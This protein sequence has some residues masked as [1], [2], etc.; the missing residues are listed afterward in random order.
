M[1]KEVVLY[2]NDLRSSECGTR[3]NEIQ[4]QQQHLE[5]NK[6]NSSM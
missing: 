3:M 4:Q 6:E 2:N 1:L 5:K